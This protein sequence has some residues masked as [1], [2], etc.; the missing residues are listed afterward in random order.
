MKTLELNQLEAVQAGDAAA[1]GFVVGL[2][3]AVGFAIGGP[4]G[5]LLGAGIGLSLSVC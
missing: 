1:C 4:G 2:G 3:A 5:L